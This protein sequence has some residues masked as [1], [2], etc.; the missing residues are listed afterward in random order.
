MAAAARAMLVNTPAA[1]AYVCGS[2]GESRTF[3]HDTELTGNMRL[4]LWVSAPGADGLDLFVTLHKIGAD[5]R[6]VFFSGYDGYSRDCVAKGWLRVSHR[7]LDPALSTPLRP[8]HTHRMEQK[9]APS[10][11]VPVEIEILPSSTLF[12]AG[13]RVRLDIQ[14]GDAARYPA[15]AH[16][17]TV[18]RGTHRI[19]CGGRFDSQLF[20][21]L[22]IR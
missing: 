17:R 16:R 1:M 4:K 15:F 13:T 19:H 3:R 11:I 22:V 12:E 8:W 21:P 10:E 7:E 14:G 20:I 2:T 5:G 9:I 6:E 18:N